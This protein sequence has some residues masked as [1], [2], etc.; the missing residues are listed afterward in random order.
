MSETIFVLFGIVLAN[1]SK[2]I[3]YDEQCAMVVV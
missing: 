2:G 3:N 1:S